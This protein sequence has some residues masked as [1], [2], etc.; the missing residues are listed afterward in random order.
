VYFN[1]AIATGSINGAQTFNGTIQLT[2]I[3]L[4]TY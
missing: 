3:N 4:G 2:W 1:T